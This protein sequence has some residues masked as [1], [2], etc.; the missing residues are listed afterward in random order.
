[1][2]YIII[3]AGA[4]GGTIG[5]RLH[6]AGHEVVLVARGEHLEKLRSTGL[7]LVTPDGEHMLGVPS[8]AGPEEL[9]L[10]SD[11]VLVLAVKSQST[12][13]ALLSWADAPVAGGTTAGAELP[14][15]TAQNGVENERAALRLFR[16]VYGMNVWLPGTFLE[17]G[18]VV[19]EGAPLSGM[20]IVGRYPTGTDATAE[21]I[22]ADLRNSRF[23]AFVEP[24][25]MRWK[26][27]K[28]L[29]NL[30]NGL[31]ALC[32]RSADTAEVARALRAEG[33]AVLAAAGIA[34]T[35]PEEE[36]AR[37]G[38]QVQIRPPTGEERQGSSTW[39]SLARGTGEVEADHLNGEIVLLGRRYGVP[40][41]VNEAVQAAVR[42]AATRRMAPGSLSVADLTALVRA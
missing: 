16:R 9:V 29:S 36:T 37:R 5:G 28:L 35:S 30:A 32:G 4:V 13:S 14:V 8:V 33:H 6:Q 19:A 23:A 20:L 41:P 7:L 18:R 10:T 11:D 42:R 15:V 39:Q 22:V 2:R 1:V 38:D 24:D 25:V 27:G 12:Q 31:D 21:A 40:T 3:G 26:H 34:Y 17:P